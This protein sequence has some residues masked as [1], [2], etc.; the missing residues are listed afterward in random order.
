MTIKILLWGVVIVALIVFGVLML[1]ALL[2][3]GAIAPSESP[4][5]SITTPTPTSAPTPTPDPEKAVRDLTGAFGVKLK[6]VSLTAPI[7]DIQQS[8]Q[9]S[10]GPFV[11]PQLL[12]QWLDDPTSAPG[13]L[14]LSPWPDRIDIRSVTALSDA[15]YEVKGDIVEV[16]SA[17][18]GTGDAA[19]K[20]PITIKVAQV[21]GEW[22]ITLVDLGAYE[23]LTRTVY[24]ND[25]YGF[26]F[27]LPSTWEG[28]SIITDTWAGFSQGDEEASETGP[29]ISIRHPL[30]TEDTPRQDI[31]VMVFT[32]EQW[33]ALQA[34]AFHIGAAPIGPSELGRNDDHV[35]AL[36]ARYNFEFLPGYEEVDDILKGGPLK[37]IEPAPGETEGT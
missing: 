16:T 4:A 22:R 33:E 21:K 9:E 29:L 35:F 30:W 24:T 20:Q 25:R 28:Y 26:R 19:A 15:N 27:S 1:P 12:A 13:R 2:G 5:P 32:L 17:E 3:D 34:E 36:P 8:I 37:P 23:D 14:V 7:D 18:V 11:S 6:D 31:P 10:Y